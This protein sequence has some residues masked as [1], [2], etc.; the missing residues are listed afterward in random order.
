MRKARTQPRRPRAGARDLLAKSYL[1]APKKSE[2]LL[3]ICPCLLSS[4]GWQDSK[5]FS[6]AIHF[7]FYCLSEYRKI[8]LRM[9]Y[10][11]FNL[12]CITISLFVYKRYSS[13]LE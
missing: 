7:M 10:K 5:T 3:L 9:K 1:F 12:T 8:Y 6:N 13:V 11:D 2:C 4:A